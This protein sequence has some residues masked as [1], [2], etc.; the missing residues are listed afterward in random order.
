MK[1][2]EISEMVL[3]VIATVLDS[4]DEKGIEKYGK[5]LDAVSLDSYDWREMALEELADCIK[6][7]LMEN[8]RL[9]REL[10]WMK[11]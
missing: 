7:L 8:M 6:Y 11:K 5:S 1:R 9:R 3:G 2:T 10:Q 4:Q